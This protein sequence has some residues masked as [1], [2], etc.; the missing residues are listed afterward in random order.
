MGQSQRG[1]KAGGFESGGVGS[2]LGNI[3]LSCTGP[4]LQRRIRHVGAKVID[5]AFVVRTSP[6]E[7]IIRMDLFT[8]TE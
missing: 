7:K 3:A 8:W 2:F 6:S 1:V 5:D 4:G